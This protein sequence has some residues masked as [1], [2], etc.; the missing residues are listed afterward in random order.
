MRSRFGKSVLAGLLALVLAMGLA[1]AGCA[2]ASNEDSNSTANNANSNQNQQQQ[3]EQTELV[4][5]LSQDDWVGAKQEVELATGINMKYV[6]MGQADGEIIIF[7]HGM[8][9]NSR[10]WSLIVP[11]FTDTY[12]VY[13][14][15]QR[16]HG[17]TDKPEAAL[18]PISQYA[19]DLA[20]FM[21]A[22]NIDKAH[23]VGHSL[24]SM[25]A[26]TFAANYPNRVDHL[27][28]ESTAPVEFDSLGRGLYDAAVSFG[29][30]QPDDEFMAGWYANP[31]PVD[32]DFLQREMKESQNIPPHAWRAITKGASFCDL[33]PFMDEITAPTLILWGSLDGFFGEELQNRIKGLLPEAQFVAYEDI[34]HNIQWEIPEQMAQ[35]VLEFLKK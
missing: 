5:E 17:D 19:E 29:E 31:N 12:Q 10:S 35:D 33:V 27:I 26:Q 30:N 18:Y 23:I 3:P 11:H 9:D 2:N 20:A 1:S 7:L 24:G 14:L 4:T 34:G 13:M 15:D 22:M 21:D 8:T 32:E 25:I 6:E 16:G 28:L